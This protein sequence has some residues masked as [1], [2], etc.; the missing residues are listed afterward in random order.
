MKKAVFAI[1]LGIILLISLNNHVQISSLKRELTETKDQRERSTVEPEEDIELGDVMTK[2][3]RHSNKLWFA[4]K[5]KNWPL[6]AFYIHELSETFED[7]SKHQIIE[8]GY[9]ISKGILDY[10]SRPLAQVD[11]AIEQQDTGV[12]QSSYQNL[13]NSCNT[14][15]ELSKHP[16]VVIKIPEKPV[17]DNQVYGP[18]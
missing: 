5:A 18:M 11:E 10:G 3:Q 13:I 4:G 6:S 9:D 14:C 15:H 2:L 1:A 17:F 12:F 16:F 7:L 8:E